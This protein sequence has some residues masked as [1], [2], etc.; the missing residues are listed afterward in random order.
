MNNIKFWHRVKLSDGTYTP[1]V[2]NHGPDG[3]DWPTVRFGLPAGLNGK[4]LIDIGAWDGFFSFEAERRGAIRITAADAPVHLGGQPNGTN[5]FQY[6]KENLKSNVDY[7]PLDIQTLKHENLKYDVVLFYGVLYHLKNPLI[8]LENAC[9]LANEMILVETAISVNSILPILEYRPGFDNDP[10][11]YFYPTIQWIE[12]VL[13]DKG[14]KTETIYND[15]VRVT[16]KGTK[17]CL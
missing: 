14:F 1:G 3:G 4:T 6:I 15:Y 10:T 11:N 5:A 16:I 17:S 9:S 13:H 12:K 2:V 8:G 7:M